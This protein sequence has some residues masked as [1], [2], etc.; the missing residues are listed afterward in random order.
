MCKKLV[1]MMLKLGIGDLTL[2]DISSVIDM[3]RK[4]SDAQVLNQAIGEWKTYNVIGMA[5]MFN[6]AI[7]FNQ[8]ISCWCVTKITSRPI[9]D[10]TGVKLGSAF[11]P[12]WGYV[13]NSE[14][15]SFLETNNT[16][17]KS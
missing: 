1:F 14:F 8:N 6:N 13:L 17:K 15:V 9:V 12:I 5:N 16:N 2:E 7:A 11:K 3:S 4:F 10:D